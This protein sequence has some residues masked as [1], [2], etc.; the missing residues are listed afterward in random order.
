MEQIHRRLTDD[1]IRLVLR[2]YCEHLIGRA[3]VEETL[4]IGKGKALLIRD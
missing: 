4:E 2:N 1:Q 3:E